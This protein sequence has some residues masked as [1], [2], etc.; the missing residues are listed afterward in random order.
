MSDKSREMIKLSMSQIRRSGE[1]LVQY[2]LLKRGIESAPM[3]TDSGVDLVVYA[4]WRKLAVTIQVK[5]NLRPKPAGGKGRMAL[6]WW[7]SEE[8][9]AELVALVDLDRQQIWL[10]RHKAFAEKAQQR[11]AGRLHFGFYVEPGIST[12]ERGAHEQDVKPFLIEN[13]ISELF[14]SPPP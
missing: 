1:L 4:P 7:L 12:G 9:P 11:S 5:S 14:G 3:T 6:D 10:F 13:R 2:R 8:S